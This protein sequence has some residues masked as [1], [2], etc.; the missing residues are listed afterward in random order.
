[1]SE[2]PSPEPVSRPAEGA[3]GHPEVDEVI[4]SLEGLENRPLP[5]HV[6]VFE[7]AH[8]RLRAALAD[9]GDPSGA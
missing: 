1:V 4:A 5:E 3:T 9:A 8:D 2:Q 6:A 7:S